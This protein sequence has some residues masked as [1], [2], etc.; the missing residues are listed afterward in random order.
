MSALPSSKKT[1][2]ERHKQILKLLLKEPA[3]KS[4]ADCKTA[5]HPR[6]ASWNLGCFV[7][8]RC[9][10]IHRSMGT[11]ILR[12]KSV[13]LDAW[14]DEQV[15]LML[16]WGN[17]KCNAFWELKLPEGYVPDG[18]KIENFIRTKYDMRKW[19]ASLQTPDPLAVHVAKSAAKP[20]SAQKPAPP[21]SKPQPQ[22][23][24][25]LLLD[26]D[27]G[28]FSLASPTP[29]PVPRPQ[30]VLAPAKPKSA[31]SALLPRAPVSAQLSGSQQAANVQNPP[32]H[33]S[34]GRSDLKKSILS[35]YSSPSSSHSNVSSPVSSQQNLPYL[36]SQLGLASLYSSSKRSP[37][38]PPP[39]REPA[40]LLSD[41]LQGLTLGSHSLSSL[42]QAKPSTQPAQNKPS[43]DNQWNDSSSSVNQWASD[44][45]LPQ[46]S[47]GVPSSG[48]LL[49][50]DLFKNV[51]N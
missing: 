29:S 27:F 15:E 16:K 6:W 45:V 10:G 4:C 36:N 12:V 9:S 40:S 25:G 47:V 32:Q 46:S 20:V 11:H 22:A 18:S 1:H 33:A 37:A 14:T 48:Q 50:D 23:A 5:A 21:V 39:S 26:D 43:W 13:D 19:A 7:C 35:L 49:D 28:T 31:S 8:I 44:S 38:S 41:S 30:P 24:S 2:S 34:N 17:S 42:P 51:W 3:N